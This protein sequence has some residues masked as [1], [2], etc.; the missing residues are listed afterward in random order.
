MD[1]RLRAFRCDRVY[2]YNAEIIQTDILYC[3]KNSSTE[4]SFFV[5]SAY[6]LRKMDLLQYARG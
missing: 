4:M 3:T 5:T 2:A 6:G 1:K